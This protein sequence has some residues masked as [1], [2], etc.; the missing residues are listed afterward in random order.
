M[1]QTHAPIKSFGSIWTKIILSQHVFTFFHSRLE[2]CLEKLHCYVCGGLV[3]NKKLECIRA[4]R[5]LC[6]QISP[7]TWETDWSSIKLKCF[8]I[9]AVQVWFWISVLVNKKFCYRPKNFNSFKTWF[10]IF[11]VSAEKS[12]ENVVILW[13]ITLK[14]N[15]RN[16]K[17]DDCMANDNQNFT[18]NFSDENSND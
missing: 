6:L 14:M 18:E 11:F 9:V 8:H 4:N 16:P 15:C 13:K 12:L 17:N 1:I 5:F 3:H 2:N 10:G 7:I